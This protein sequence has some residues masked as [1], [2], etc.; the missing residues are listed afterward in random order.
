MS[1]G[2]ILGTAQ[3][4]VGYGITNGSRRLD[5]S[6]VSDILTE[7]SRRNVNIFDTAADYGDAQERLGKFM[8]G[9]LTA[10]YVSKFSLGNGSVTAGATFAESM[11]RLA[12]GALYGLLVHRIADFEDPRFP[13]ALEILRDARSRGLVERLGVSVYDIDDLELALDR[14]PD[15]D[16]VQFPAS[17]VD[18]RLIAHPLIAQ[19][20]ANGVETHIRSAFLQGLLLQ[21]VDL[22]A[23]RFEGLRPALSALDDLAESRGVNRLQLVLGALKA[24]EVVDAVVV[25]ATSVD[26]LR[27]IS[28]AWAVNL[29]LTDVKL[30]AVPME[31]IDPRR[32][33]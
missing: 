9:S 19:L 10:R 22:L 29:T 2:L 6:V 8:P 23:P 32:W 17:I 15:L 21:S 27:A 3:F 16:L 5:D 7:A 28:D 24:H 25:G 12:T 26:E 33:G 30:P 4:G 18:Q 11:E 1:A 14:M 20:H 31:I 13:A